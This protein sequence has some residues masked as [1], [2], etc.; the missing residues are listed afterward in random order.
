VDGCSVPNWTAE[1]VGQWLTSIQLSDHVAMLV[2]RNITGVQLLQLDSSQMKV[3][4]TSVAFTNFC[5][6]M[7]YISAAYAVMRCLFVH[8][9]MCLSHSCIL[10]KRIKMLS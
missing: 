6:A 1:Q 4:T 3:V 5:R 2:S 8:P 9:S 7:L 10:S